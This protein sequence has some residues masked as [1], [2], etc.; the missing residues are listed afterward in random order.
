MN[1]IDETEMEK[2]LGMFWL[3]NEDIFVFRV[4]FGKVD[5][6]IMKQ[7]RLPTKREV[8]KVVMSHFDLIRVLAP[9]IFLDIL[10][11]KI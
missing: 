2:F 11:L 6:K 5:L 10:Y 4:N 8:L 3:I 1:Q 7:L 9:T